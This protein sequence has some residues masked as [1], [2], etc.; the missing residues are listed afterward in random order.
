MGIKFGITASVCA[1]IN[2]FFI[3]SNQVAVALLSRCSSAFAFDS[4]S[5]GDCVAALS[6]SGAPPSVAVYARREDIQIAIAV[7]RYNNAFA[8]NYTQ[9]VDKT[10]AIARE[11]SLVLVAL[12]NSRIQCRSVDGLASH[13]CQA[14][15]PSHQHRIALL[16]D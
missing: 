2:G 16:P 12:A 13:L 8:T 3:S 7:T 4:N 11:K 10:G 14:G 15:V 1:V 5:F 9:W 6:I